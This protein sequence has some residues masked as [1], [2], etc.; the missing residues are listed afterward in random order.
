MD[1]GTA[2]CE[3][4]GRPGIGQATNERM[5]YEFYGAVWDMT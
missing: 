5:K 3:M 1:N 2:E 4:M